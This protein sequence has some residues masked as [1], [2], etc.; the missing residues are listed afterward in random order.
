MNTMEAVRHML[1][2]GMITHPAY[3]IANEKKPAY[4]VLED[5]SFY[6]ISG[7][8]GKRKVQFPIQCTDPTKYKIYNGDWYG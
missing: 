6:M 7:Y 3:E 2:G 8:S 4:F 5:D 1:N